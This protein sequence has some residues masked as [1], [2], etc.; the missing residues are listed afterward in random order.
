LA[1]QDQI[2]NWFSE[3]IEEN[4]DALYSAALRLTR[5]DSDAQDLV[6]D[7]VI[8]AWSCIGSLTDPG[9]FRPWIFR[10]MRNTFISDY[11]K[12]SVR[13][14]ESTFLEGSVHDVEN[15]SVE[16]FASWLSDLPD[17]FLNWWASP[18]IAL[19]NRLLGEQ[20]QAAIDLLPP[21]FKITVLLINVDGLTYDETAAML[22]V[23]KGTVRSR[24]KRGRTLLQKALWT[25]AV[26]AG[27]S[28]TIQGNRNEK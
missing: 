4:M 24:M 7:A 23:P 8:K 17:E 10:I 5:M 28:A 21:V 6:A 14:K 26:E 19:G 2:R 13:P 12:K 16:D 18:E 20:I 3:R 25:Q 22:G 9:R 11:R 27:L 1:E 15:D